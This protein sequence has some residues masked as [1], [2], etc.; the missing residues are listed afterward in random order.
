MN[1][2]VLRVAGK[3]L[4]AAR[5]R[6][7]AALPSLVSLSRALAA[8]IAM[9]MHVL[10]NVAAAF[11][12][13]L[14]ASD[15]AVTTAVAYRPEPSGQQARSMTVPRGPMAMRLGRFSAYGTH[16]SGEDVMR[17]VRGAVALSASLDSM[18]SRVDRIA[19]T[20][21]LSVTQRAKLHEGGWCVLDASE[22]RV[23][24]STFGID[25]RRFYRPLYSQEQ[26]RPAPPLQTRRTAIADC[27]FR[28][29][30]LPGR[31]RTSAR[32]E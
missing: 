9:A 27:T 29:P 32:A 10:F 21:Y 3:P 20:A 5:W 15:V 2:N 18:G 26:V 24:N 7:A 31:A 8:E 23:G 4:T 30:F 28:R 25:M 16:Y 1:G 13:V 6:A 19:I 17:Y 12:G 14:S 22:R 11:A